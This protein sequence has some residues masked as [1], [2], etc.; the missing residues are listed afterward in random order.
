MISA[1]ISYCN[2]LKAF[3]EEKDLEKAKV[4]ILFG[5][6]ECSIMVSAALLITIFFKG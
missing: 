1:L 4:Y 6:L 2:A 5:L 3:H